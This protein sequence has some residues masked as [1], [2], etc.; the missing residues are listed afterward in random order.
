MALKIYLSN[1]SR[2]NPT[3]EV[4][5]LDFMYLS[6]KWHLRSLAAGSDWVHQKGME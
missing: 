2:K 4:A 3:V 6:A 1:S 5:Q